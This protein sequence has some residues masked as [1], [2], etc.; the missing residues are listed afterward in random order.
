VLEETTLA[1]Y[2]GSGG[3]DLPPDV[4]RWLRELRALS[5]GAED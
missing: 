3:T 4:A 2:S 5:I 1:G